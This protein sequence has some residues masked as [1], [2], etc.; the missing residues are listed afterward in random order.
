MTALTT[1]I[2][3]PREG[4]YFSVDLEAVASGITAVFG[5]SGSGKTT[6]LHCISGLERGATGFVGFG[7]RV[8]HDSAQ[9][10]FVPPH[11]R[12]IA[13]VFQEPRLFQ[14]LNVNANL[15]YG[16]KR[17]P[18]TG[19]RIAANKVIDLLG[20]GGLLAR[21]PASLSLGEQQRVAIGRALLAS[22]R[23]LLMDEPLA[24]LDIRRKREILPFLR[25]LP[26]EF[27]IPVIYVSHAI[28][29]LYQLA[30]WVV[31]LNEGKV[32]AQGGIRDVF[33]R[34]DLFDYLEE[35][36]GAVL[37]TRVLGHEPEYE[38]TLLGVDD[39]K[40]YIPK[41]DIRVGEALRIYVLASNVS[42]AIALPQAPTSVLNILEG[43]VLE[44]GRPNEKRHSLLVK[45]DIAGQALL[46]RITQK[47]LANL[48]L[49]PGMKVYAYIKAVS[50]D[51]H[52]V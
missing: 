39:E 6:L 26:A 28:S 35:Q 29:E 50:L 20:I 16:L 38:L 32:V 24:S 1:R 8:W 17:T 3:L 42:L 4:F 51:E 46:A 43:R 40:L 14:H 47:S 52:L 15:N 25:K 7:E 30:D 18:P 41:R 37:E 23:L 9:R 48:A 45:V 33:S 34:L 44:V 31:L 10:I 12:D 22:P 2:Q 36:T 5:P 11:R 27:D 13:M 19:R 21:K 49:V